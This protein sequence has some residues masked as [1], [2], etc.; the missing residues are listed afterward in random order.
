[1]AID[2]HCP[3]CGANLQVAENYAG[4]RVRCPKCAGV[5]VVPQTDA[6]AQLPVARPI[7]PPRR[8]PPRATG[9]TPVP[10]AGG[11][12]ADAAGAST[13]RASTDAAGG[14]LPNIVVD[15]EAGSLAGRRPLLRSGGTTAGGRGRKTKAAAGPKPKARR[16]AW[17][18]ASG[19]SAAVLAVVVVA[20]LVYRVGG[21]WP[22]AADQ[23]QAVLVL[24]WPE[25]QRSG[26][27]VYIDGRQQELPRSG[28]AEFTLKPGP[29]R[30][31]MLR[32]GYEQVETRIS[33]KADQRHQYQPRWTEIAA[34]GDR[35]KVGRG[36]DRFAEPAG[37]WLQDLEAAK[38]QAAGKRDIL[39]AFEGSEPSEQWKQAWKN[40]FDQREFR[41]QMGWRFV[42]V[43]ID[44][45]RG[46]DAQ[47][48]IEDPQRNKRLA[49]TYHVSKE[50]MVVLT[51]PEGRPYAVEGPSGDAVESFVKDLARWQDS[52]G[53]KLNSLL[54]EVKRSSGQQQLAAIEAAA[55][56]LTKA[57]L[58]KWELIRFYQ[59]TLDDWRAKGADE[60]VFGLSW[61]G[62]LAEADEEDPKAVRQ[63]IG[64]LDD[65]KRKHQFKDPNRAAVMHAYAAIRLASAAQ[66]SDAEKYL[67]EA[68]AYKP[69]DPLAF[70]MLE[71]AKAAIHGEGSGSGTGFMVAA[72]GHILTNYHVI[73][74]VSKTSVRLPGR[75][76]MLPVKVL[77]TDRQRD[78]ALLKIEIP[79]GLKLAPLRIA[80]GEVSVGAEVG[81]FGFPLG[82]EFSTEVT[83]TWGHVGSKRGEEKDRMLVLDCRVNPGNSG[84]PLC[85]AQG[86]VVGMVTAK[87]SGPGGV[88]SYGMAL[89]AK[90]LREFLKK[91]LPG[92][93][94][95]Q[96]A[97]SGGARQGW[98]EINPV[99]SP[100]VVMILRSQ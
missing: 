27:A 54:G 66:S 89:P 43:R 13:D 91:H 69:A 45:P 21:G 10:P 51:D 68:A 48:Q 20:V 85:D 41:E 42:W 62:R 64:E 12:A 16:P 57:L 14:G 61:L 38:R 96:S 73:E 53:W 3:S 98:D 94:E 99:V 39:I 58:K 80:A 65:W 46:T 8:R 30:V 19:V 44:F 4:R 100:S 83:F 36:P 71:R 2:C 90:D 78:I 47:A 24:D 76:D 67:Q 6:P 52:V 37:A 87:V 55:D 11:P 74:G 97:A 29:H 79:E 56:L 75:K 32:R 35:P 33:L 92:Y 17:L 18:L 28:P 49:E 93:D 5:I 9:V 86:H 82:V 25:T 60:A 72:D 40:I 88:D 81:V 23:E 77:A 70:F 31:V 1:M 26:A 34:A 95:Q 22:A 15:P 7:V 50:S 63:V 59:P 84:G